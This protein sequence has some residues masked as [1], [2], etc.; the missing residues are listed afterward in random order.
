MLLIG[1]IMQV[2]EREVDE[3]PLYLPLRFVVN[4]SC[5]KKVLNKK[6]NG[7]LSVRIVKLPWSAHRRYKSIF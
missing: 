6:E 2:W 3:K 7:T 1:E 5:P 4:Q